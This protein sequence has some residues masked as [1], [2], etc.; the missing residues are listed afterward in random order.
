MQKFRYSKDIR[1]TWT[2]ITAPIPHSIT[3]NPED[4]VIVEA[5]GVTTTVPS[6]T[7]LLIGPA[8]ITLITAPRLELPF[9]LISASG[10]IE[11][12]NA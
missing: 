4:T 8:E 5:I 7:E 9:Q 12:T 6:Q 3:A 11:V 2:T 10:N 1:Q